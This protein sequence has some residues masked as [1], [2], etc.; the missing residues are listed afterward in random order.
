MFQTA[1]SGRVELGLTGSDDLQ[2]K[3]SPDGSDWARGMCVSC[4]SG[5]VGVGTTVP[6]VRLDVNGTI[7]SASPA[8]QPHLTNA[9]SDTVLEPGESVDI[10]DFSGL[11]FVVNM[12]TGGLAQ[13][14]VLSDF[15]CC[16]RAMLPD[17]DIITDMS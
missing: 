14:P 13:E 11:V 7:R 10:P 12:T 8:G 9:D 4:A 2:I 5:F 3:V 6:S 17:V 15:C 16:V 1:F